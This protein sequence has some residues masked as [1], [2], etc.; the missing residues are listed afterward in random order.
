MFRKSVMKTAVAVMLSAVLLAGC[1]S[2][3]TTSASSSAA[4]STQT[5][6]VA[7]STEVATEESSS[8]ADTEQMGTEEGTLVIKEQ[9]AFASGGTVTDPVGGEYDPTQSFMDA[10]RAGNTAHVDHASV[11]YQI[12]VND[13]GHPIVY[14]HGYGQSRLGWMTTPD[15]RDGWSEIFLRKGHASFLVDQPRR[16]EAGNTASMTSDGLD[17]SENG[18]SKNHLPGDQAW[19]THFRIGR[20]APE[21]YEGSQFPA[22]DGAQNQFFRM[23]TPNTGSFDEPLVA[24]A[25]GDVLQD[26]KDR[27]GS[28][29]IYLTHSQ[30]GLVG[31]D[32]DMK[33]VAAIIAIEP[34]STPEKG[35]D[36][37]NRMLAA[38]VPVVIYF[39]DYI[40][41]GPSDLMSTGFWQNTEQRAEQFAKDY[42]ADGGDARVISLPDIGIRGNSHFMFE[43]MN[44][45][46]IAENIEQWLTQH[47][48]G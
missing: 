36:Q 19:Y 45:K 39:G 10:T 21:R 20:V 42:T 26:V 29:S 14:L 12:P 22:D 23:F 28:K 32:T 31:W 33:N 1:G 17:A 15:G 18:N 25:M 11:F 2:A 4:A 27:T 7:S 6:A 40:K 35:S 38:K 3:G 24:D 34:G 30:G 47:D 48:L 41:N 43:E 8:K 5:G 44:N 13:D 16:G 37:Y 46:E 9:G